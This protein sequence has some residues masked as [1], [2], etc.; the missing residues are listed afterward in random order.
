M[1]AKYVE[2]DEDKINV[3]FETNGSIST[4]EVNIEF[5]NRTVPMMAE[6]AAP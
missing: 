6:M 1:I 5:P 4:L 3:D 2:I